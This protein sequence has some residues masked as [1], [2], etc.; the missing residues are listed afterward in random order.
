MGSGGHPRPG[1]VLKQLG[2][3]TNPAR[4]SSTSPDA[5]GLR[6]SPAADGMT[7]MA[8]AGGLG[9]AILLRAGTDDH[10]AVYGMST[11]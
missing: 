10:P 3:A 4:P 8:D 7:A 2:L 1:R 6:W 5:G 9:P 11:F